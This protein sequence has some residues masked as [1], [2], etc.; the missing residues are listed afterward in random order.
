M[1]AEFD[2]HKVHKVGARF[3]KEK[4]EWFNHQYLQN[5]LMKSFLESFKNLEET[6][7]YQSSD[8]TC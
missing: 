1:A 3:S 8:E 5:S 2:L 4:A 7:K 6:K